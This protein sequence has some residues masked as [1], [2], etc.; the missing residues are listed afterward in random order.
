M[1]LALRIYA[2]A[3]RLYPRDFQQQHS[4]AMLETYTD[5]L[6]DATLYKR[7]PAFHRH[8]MLDL[9]SSLPAAHL[10][11]ANMDIWMRRLLIA[12]SLVIGLIAL[13]QAVFIWSHQTIQLPVIISVTGQAL[14]PRN[15]LW[16]TL[17][18]A[19]PT[20]YAVQWVM[21]VLWIVGT[22]VFG[23]L[24][25]RHATVERRWAVAPPFIIAL[26]LLLALI[27]ANA[28]SIVSPPNALIKISVTLMFALGWITFALSLRLKPQPRVAPDLS[29]PRA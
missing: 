3:L 21:I 10:Q 22:L 28:L 7:L 6:K 9:I 14:D 8:M 1:K 17:E 18:Q 16:W 26:A 29:S 2:W 27:G 13:V 15:A 19:M 20:L 23:A 12:S 24:T 11:G 25:T 4:Q 5:A